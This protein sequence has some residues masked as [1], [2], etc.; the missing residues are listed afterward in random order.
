MRFENFGPEVFLGGFL[1][2]DKVHGLNI[3]CIKGSEA[4][5]YAEACL[6]R[7]NDQ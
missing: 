5:L 4:C 6:Y 1:G 3:L 7:I 2:L